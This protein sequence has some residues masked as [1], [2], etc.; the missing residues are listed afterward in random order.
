MNEQD[1]FLPQGIR[2]YELRAEEQ[3]AARDVAAK[4]LSETI[5]K[6]AE[7][8]AERLKQERLRAG[9]TEAVVQ[10]AY[11]EL[12]NQRA[13]DAEE[14][15]RNAVHTVREPDEIE[16][17]FERRGSVVLRVSGPIP[18]GCENSPHYG[19]TY[20]EVEPPADPVAE[21]V[22]TAKEAEN[23]KMNEFRASMAR[24]VAAQKGDTSKA[25][26]LP[27]SDAERIAELEA[28][29]ADLTTKAKRKAYG[30]K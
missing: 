24:Q 19:R 2:S 14:A 9:G 11:K 27:K 22:K 29:V 1:Q 20:E 21:A 16:Y 15:A 6:D 13:K 7:A 8:T 17:H 5:A 23:R 10:D 3:R 30:S 18:A 28:Q 12:V 4:E 26:E 25:M